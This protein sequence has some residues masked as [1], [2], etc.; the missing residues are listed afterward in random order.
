ML[1]RA[2]KTF[3]AKG[4]RLSTLQVPNLAADTPTA[5]P[6]RRA[7]SNLAPGAYIDDMRYEGVSMST[8]KAVNV[9][10][11]KVLAVSVVSKPKRVRMACLTCSEKHLKCDEGLPYCLNCQNS[12]QTCKRHDENKQIDDQ[13]HS[14]GVPR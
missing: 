12:N 7:S 3:V 1:A 5:R 4:D 10:V 2:A 11:T 6:T 8:P 14:T 13:S 9:E